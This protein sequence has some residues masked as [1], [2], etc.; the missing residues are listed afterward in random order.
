M[1]LGGLGDLGFGEVERLRGQE[2]AETNRSIHGCES[3][4]SNPLLTSD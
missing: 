4:P 1:I 3:V 2:K